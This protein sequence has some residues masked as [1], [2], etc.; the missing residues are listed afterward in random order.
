M[1]GIAEHITGIETVLQEGAVLSRYG[2]DYRADKG[3]VAETINK[4]H[5]KRIQYTV[6]EIRQEATLILAPT[7]ISGHLPFGACGKAISGILC[8]RTGTPPASTK[9]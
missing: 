9:K 3:C 8:W 4:Y 5:P 6:T 2:R 1:S 7:F